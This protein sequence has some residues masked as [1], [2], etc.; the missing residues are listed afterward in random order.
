MYEF[1][2]GTEQLHF[3]MGRCLSDLIH[4]MQ[5]NV[6]DNDV[7]FYGQALANFSSAAQFCYDLSMRERVKMFCKSHVADGVI[8]VVV[9]S[10]LEYQAKEFLSLE[11]QSFILILPKSLIYR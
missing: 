10:D 3:V 11:K 5:K 1:R 8:W 2:Y 9:V 4:V 6:V 7:D